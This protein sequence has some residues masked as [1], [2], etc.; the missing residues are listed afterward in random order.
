EDGV[1]RRPALAAEERAGDLARGV[2][3]LLD[4]DRQREEVELVLRVL[5]GRGGRQQHGLAV[6]VGDGT[7]GRLL[8]QSAGLEADGAGAVA[9]V[10][11]DSFGELDLGTL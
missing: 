3:L 1:S 6:E 7:A 10:V 8:G 4:V 11:D 2:H 9:A 5:A